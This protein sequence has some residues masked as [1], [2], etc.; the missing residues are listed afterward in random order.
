[1]IVAVTGGR[2][3]ADW[4]II[5]STLDA[6]HS[7]TAI[8]VLVQGGANGADDIARTWAITNTVQI[9]EF[10]VTGTQWTRLGKSAGPTRNR[11]MLEVTRP[12]LLVAFPGGSGTANCVKTARELG[13]E[14]FEVQS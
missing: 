8:S 11:L 13:I 14:V 10:R 3:F 7:K 4:R 2:E 9:A 6:L 1:M 5:D 12:N